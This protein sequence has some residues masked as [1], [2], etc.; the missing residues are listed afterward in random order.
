[1]YADFTGLSTLLIHVGSDEMMLSDSTRLSEKASKVGVEVKIKIWQG[2]WHVFPF[3]APF[4]PEASQAIAEI[5]IFI[6]NQQ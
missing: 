1:L 6:Q 5:G 3:F 4:V 2:V